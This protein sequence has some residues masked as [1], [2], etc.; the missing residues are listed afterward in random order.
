MASHASQFCR[1]SFYGQCGTALLLSCSS[2]L[3]L[4]LSNVMFFISPV[5]AVREESE[6]VIVRRK[7]SKDCLQMQDVRQGVPV[8]DTGLTT[9]LAQTPQEEVEGSWGQ[10][11][12]AGKRS[13]ASVQLPLL[14]TPV[15]QFEGSQN[16]SH[17]V[18][19]Q[20]AGGFEGESCPE[21][22]EGFGEG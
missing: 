5:P 9:S 20:E 17:R 22:K 13:R 18:S 7:I 21:V 4:W 12:A 15:L 6:E 16:T 19:R 1:L 8:F 2:F 10:T 11:A 14:S 3:L